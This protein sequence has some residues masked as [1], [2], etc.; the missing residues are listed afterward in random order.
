[1]EGGGA[2]DTIVF[3]VSGKISLASTLPATKTLNLVINGGGNITLDGGGSNQIF[4]VANG[5]L[6]PKN[7]TLQN[8]SGVNGGAI[9]AS[10]TVIAT[11]C[12]FQNNKASGL[13]GA[14]YG[15]SG[16]TIE[17][18]GSTFTSNTATMGGGAIYG[19]GAVSASGSTFTSNSSS[20]GAGGAIDL[21]DP[22]AV[23]VDTSTFSSNTSAE[24]GA[25]ISNSSV[26]NSGNIATSTFSSNT[27]ATGDGGAIANELVGAGIGIT[28]CT[29]V[30]NSAIEGAGTF[31]NGGIIQ[32]H[33]CTFSKN[34]TTGADGAVVFDKSTLPNGTAVSASILT[35]TANGGN[36][37][38]LEGRII[39]GSDNISDDKTC[40]FAGTG[41]QGQTLGDGVSPKAR[42]RRLGQQRRPHQ[43]R[44][45]VRGQ[46]IGR[47]SVLYGMRQ[48][49]QR[50]P[51]RRTPAG[52]RRRGQWPLRRRRV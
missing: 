37:N 44:R 5:A 35:A 34:F 41:A 15:A 12:I 26:T 7:L 9:S 11:N 14:I 3:S 17:I 38:G 32:I 19:S 29:F 45:G 23:G 46:R 49:R 16:V 47:R 10:A 13:G 48:S 2:G 40:G 25:A 20:S 22:G 42:S 6:D 28:N 21:V 50:G 8:G 31:N 27:T 33:D 36:C 52:P 30:G 18:H 1:M 24:D 4:Q 43:H 39:D 51:A